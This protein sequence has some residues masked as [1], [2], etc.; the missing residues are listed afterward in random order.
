MVFESNTEIFIE[1]NAFWKCRPQ[2]AGHLFS[3]VRDIYT[4]IHGVVRNMQFGNSNHINIEENAFGNVNKMAISCRLQW[5]NSSR[6]DDA[7][8]RE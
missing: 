1:G 4:G 3:T 5:V 8:M 7:Y 6:P 2:N